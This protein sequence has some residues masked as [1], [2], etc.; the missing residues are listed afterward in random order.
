MKIEKC[1]QRFY[2]N[3]RCLRVVFGV[4]Q[5]QMAEILGISIGTLRKIERGIQTPRT[6][7]AILWKASDAFCVSTDI[8]LKVDFQVPEDANPRRVNR[9]GGFTFAGGTD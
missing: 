5:A 4:S 2:R 8:L 9:R 3:L 6:S 7:A 1:T